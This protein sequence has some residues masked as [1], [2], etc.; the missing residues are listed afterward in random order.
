[1]NLPGFIGESSIYRTAGY[2]QHAIAGLGLHAVVVPATC[3][4]D[5]CGPCLNGYQTCCIEGDTHTSSPAMTVRQRVGRARL[6]RVTRRL[7]RVGQV[8]EHAPT[9]TEQ[10]PLK[11]AEPKSVG[12]LVQM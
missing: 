8:R 4:Q 10:S 5:Y 7:V 3:S 2:Y 9:V 12:C 11:A 6:G 1:M